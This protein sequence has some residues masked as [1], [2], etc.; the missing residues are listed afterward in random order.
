MVTTKKAAAP[1]VTPNQNIKLPEAYQNLSPEAREKAV[2][3]IAKR[4]ADMPKVYRGN[5]DKAM[6]GNSLRAAV[7]ASCLEC[8][9]WQREEVRLCPSLQCPSWPYRPYQGVSKKA[10]ERGDSG[11]ESTNADNTYEE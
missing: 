3:R 7:H 10:P 2:E 5:Y 8:V 4:R 11:A 6:E 1:T 9:M